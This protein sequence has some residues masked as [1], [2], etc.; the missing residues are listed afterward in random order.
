ME[1]VLGSEMLDSTVW[2]GHWA[3]SHR[4][5]PRPATCLA[6]GTVQQ[7]CYVLTYYAVR[8]TGL[9]HAHR[10]PC[11]NGQNRPTRRSVFVIGLAP[12]PGLP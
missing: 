6:A 9:L 2:P 8:C 4:L 12:K 1:Q 7:A 3:L 5:S 11:Y 10:R